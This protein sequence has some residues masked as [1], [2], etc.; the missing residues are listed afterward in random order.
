MPPAVAADRGGDLCLASTWRDRFIGAPEQQVRF[1]VGP[2][3]TEGRARILAAGERPTGPT[4]S[5]R[6]TFQ[7]GR[8]GRLASISCG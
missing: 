3:V 7:L 4:Y 5:N 2:L 1:E 6:L 8:D